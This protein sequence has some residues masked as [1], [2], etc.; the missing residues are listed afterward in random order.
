MIKQKQYQI[1]HRGV[2]MKHFFNFKTIN[3]K[4]IVGFTVVILISSLL[5]VYNLFSFYATNKK[6]EDIVDQQLQFV[7]A[8]DQLA[9]NVSERL[10][11]VRGYILYG[12]NDYR[13]KF[14]QYTGESKNI[15]EQILKIDKSKEV[16]DLFAKQEN[17]ERVI[18]QDV[19]TELSKGNEEQALKTL[20]EKVE[21]LSDELV[22]AYSTQSEKRQ[23]EI[24]DM[25]DQIIH[26]GQTSMMISVIISIIV[27][28]SS[29][30]VAFFTG[31]SISKPIKLVEERMNLIASGNLSGKPLETQLL[32]ETGHLIQS[33]NRMNLQMRELI[34]KIKSV[35]DTVTSQSE[36]LTQSANEVK[37]GAEQ[38]AVTMQNLAANAE[39]QANR[40]ERLSSIMKSFHEKVEAAN[41]NGVRVEQ[42]SKHILEMSSEGGRLMSSSTAQMEKIDSIVKQTVE[43][44]QGLDTESQKISKLVSVIKEIADQTNL[45]ALNAAI[46]AARAGEH[47]K[48]FAV[49][50]DEVRK[51]AEQVSFSVKDITGIVA[52]IQN[53]VS[54]VTDVLEE[55][56]TE[57]EQG[58]SQIKMTEER[59]KQINLAITE[60]ANH[61][62]Q[63]S[64]NLADIANNSE[65]MSVS[66]H[67]IAATAQEAAAGIEQTSASSQQTSS[68]M[69][70]ITE[71]SN[72]LAKLADEMNK[73][74]GTFKL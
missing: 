10:A 37:A 44:V 38:T 73:L 23:K 35:S 45:L 68:S 42:T 46:E 9:Y 70:I 7:I 18:V 8:N 54:E 39:T 60:M 13:K 12:D 29:I 22:T 50:A 28:I 11:L 49:V 24:N 20:S 43:K 33:T 6:T 59:F 34:S 71:S 51:L 57:V 19:Y 16:K 15:Q 62:K 14:N 66:V 67:E 72:L 36:E 1:Y 4:I 53:E 3:K 61:I 41:D 52:N 26:S 25:G 32:D 40:A 58:T 2:N 63:I 74:I 55:G 64:M 30:I 69:E 56:Y 21:P 27:I 47:G 5:V 31:K 17:W 65:E 48:G